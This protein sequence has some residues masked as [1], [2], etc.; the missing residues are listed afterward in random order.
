MSLKE[1]IRQYQDLILAVLVLA[2]YVHLSF[3]VTVKCPVR[4]LTGISCPSCG[5]SRAVFALC[6]LD[7]AA[8][9]AA[10]P[11]IFY[12]IPV[13]P[14]LLVAYLRK[15]KKLTDVLLWITAGVLI[16]VY[17]YR[18][19]VLQSPALEADWSKGFIAGLFQ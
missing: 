14:V 12:L 19:L 9:W 6:K 16:A 13:A 4:W 5:L 11:A 1:K 15:A 17:L 7:F 10:N 3:V 18:I 8:A 2:V